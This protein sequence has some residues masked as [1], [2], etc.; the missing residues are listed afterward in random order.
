MP[1]E[2]GAYL[3]Q[4]AKGHEMTSKEKPL[5]IRGASALGLY[6]SRA[7]FRSFFPVCIRDELFDVKPCYQNLLA[8]EHARHLR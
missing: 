3:T 2:C 1:K 7:D 5:T 6:Y 4:H 8:A